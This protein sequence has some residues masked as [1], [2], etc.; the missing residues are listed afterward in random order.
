[1]DLA[2]PLAWPQMWRTHSCVPC[3][4]SCEHKLAFIKPSVGTSADA[5]RKSACATSLPVHSMTKKLQKFALALCVFSSSAV[6]LLAQQTGI[7]GEW[8][9]TIAGRLRVI[10]R[11]DHAADNSWH[12][13]LESIDQGHAKIDIDEVSFD[14][15]KALQLEMKKIGA[16]YKSELSADSSELVGTWEQGGAAVPLTLRRPGAAPAELKPAARGRVSLKPCTSSG[17][18]ALC[19]SYEVFENRATQTGRKIALRVMVLPA[20]TDKPAPD[21][22]FGFAGG[23]GQ[24]ASEAY[25]LA[26]VTIGLRKQ[27]DVVL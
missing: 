9:G 7:S 12:A 23:P 19:G 6:C 26:P 1:M 8:D 5:A 20:A 16:S 10:V 11:I 17:G 22:V 14:G 21:A 24:A 2:G 3:S 13:S 18:P 15:K 4:H 25:P 27:R